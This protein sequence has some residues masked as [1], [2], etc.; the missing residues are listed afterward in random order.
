M[1]F[2]WHVLVKE[3]F[4]ISHSGKVN[5]PVTHSHASWLNSPA[6]NSKRKRNQETWS[7][8]AGDSA[9]SWHDGITISRIPSTSSEIS[10]VRDGGVHFVDLYS[11]GP[12]HRRSAFSAL[13]NKFAI[14]HHFKTCSTWSPNLFIIISTRARKDLSTRRI[15]AIFSLDHSCRTAHTSRPRSRATR[16]LRCVFKFLF[17]L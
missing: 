12:R 10:S 5:V 4:S 16:R 1:H 8:S 7:A 2:C 3:K 17:Y 15:V 14:T 9:I 6:K 13:L 11:S